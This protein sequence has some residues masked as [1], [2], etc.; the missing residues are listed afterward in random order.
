MQNLFS[1]D[2]TQ[3]TSHVQYHAGYTIPTRPHELDCAGQIHIRK[4]QVIDLSV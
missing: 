4:E 3:K 2:P 1:I